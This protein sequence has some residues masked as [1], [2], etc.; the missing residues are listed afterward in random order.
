MKKKIIISLILAIP[1]LLCFGIIYYLSSQDNMQTNDLSRNFTQKIAGIL[2]KNFSDMDRDIRQTI[3]NELN[4]FIRKTAH[5]SVYLLMG[6]FIYAEIV[7]W[8]KKYFFSIIATVGICMI[9]AA[10]DEF[11][12]SLVPGRTPLVNDVII[13]SFGALIGS[14]ICFSA[15]SAIYF[16][17]AHREK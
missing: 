17:I 4:L 7:F 11:H 12:Q 6:I 8:I 5:F 13:D 10:I 15:I 1:V 2:F 3:I 14:L 16:I 9:Y